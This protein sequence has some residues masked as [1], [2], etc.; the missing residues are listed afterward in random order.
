MLASGADLLKL[1]EFRPYVFIYEMEV[2]LAPLG[3]LY[4]WRVDDAFQS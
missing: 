2:I 4:G 3:G 1:L